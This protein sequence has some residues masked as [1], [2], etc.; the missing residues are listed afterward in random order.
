MSLALVIWAVKFVSRMVIIFLCDRIGFTDMTSLIVYKRLF[1]YRTQLVTSVLIMIV[2]A[3]NLTFVPVVGKFFDGRF[4]DFT[5][6]WYEIVGS[7]FVISM[8]LNA[9]NPFIEAIIVK[10]TQKIKKCLD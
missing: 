9:I 6:S 7:L 4:R 5:K 1:L 2:L 8:V 10:L 3:A